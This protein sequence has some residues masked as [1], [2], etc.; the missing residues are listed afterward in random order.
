MKLILILPFLLMTLTAAA[1]QERKPVRSHSDDLYV[2]KPIS[3][4]GLFPSGIEGP[5]VDSNGHLYAVNFGSRGTIGVVK[6]GQI[7][8]LWLKLPTGSIGNSIRI[9]K[10]GRMFVADYKM[11]QLFSVDI[12][13]KKV[14]VLFQANEMNQP[15]DMTISSNNTFFL[16]DPNWKDLKKGSIWSYKIGDAA[17]VKM[18]SDLAAVNGIDLDASET[19]LY[20]SESVTGSIFSMEIKDNTL[21][22]K[23]LVY[24][25]A[26]DTVDGIRFDSAGNLF[27]ARIQQSK[28][29]VIST[30]GKLLRSI[31]LQGQNPTNLAFGGPDGKT[32]YVTIR[33]G[34]YIESFRT[35]NP[36]R[37]WVL[38]SRGSRR[39]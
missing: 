29:D 4:P 33:D 20:F 16:S 35:E 8:E 7:P 21:I 19:H 23:K 39:P 3:S 28:I 22:N 25:F 36:G 2:S 31:A 34:G 9:N 10:D 5:A 1:N 32:V 26:P 30:D 13:T 27:V 15:N 14:D 17:P 37:E 18:A 6:P 12:E 24:K 11:H 38:R